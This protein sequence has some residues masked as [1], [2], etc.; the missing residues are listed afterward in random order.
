MVIVSLL[1]CVLFFTMFERKFMSYIQL[2]KGPNKV[3]F[4]GILTP[5]ADTVKLVIKTS[6]IVISSN[7]LLFF[8]GPF[9][10][11]FVLFLMWSIMPF[12]FFNNVYFFSLVVF[13]CLSS[14]NVY[15]VLSSGWGSNS[16]YSMLGA[17]RGVAQVI[18]YEIIL[19]F[20][21]FFPICSHGGY[22][23]FSFFENNFFFLMWFFSLFCV[24]LVSCVAE[25]NRSPFDFAEGESELV[26]GFNTE[27]GALEFAFLFLGEYGQII[28]I[29]SLSVLIFSYGYS[30]YEYILFGVLLAV[31]FIWFRS[32]FPRF[33]YDLF[34]EIAWNW[35]L[36]FLVF[37]IF[38]I[39]SF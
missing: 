1:L 12:F 24:W 38:Y 30:G 36:V 22:Q 34:M 4:L 8:F 35:G 11:I 10:A 19:I 28:F 39:V 18:S 13:F 32:S 27:Y 20:V 2:R 9:L 14:I 17:F 25:T 29:S 7:Q 15:S 37:Y 33:R 23:M 31:G 5:V 3:G 6:S 21:G 16:K 26:S